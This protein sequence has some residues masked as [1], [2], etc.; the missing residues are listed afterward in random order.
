PG[1]DGLEL[2]QKVRERDADCT[3][4]VM[5]AFGAVDTAVSAMRLGACDYLTKPLNFEEL[6]I[7]IERALER[8]R[9]ES[10]AGTLRQ[11]LSERYR[12]DNI[13]GDSQPMQQVYKVVEQVAPSRATVL[14][15]G[16]SGTGKELV[17][18]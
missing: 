18:A 11:R 16:E 5:T 3:V 6:M 4:I 12:L 10:E 2:M 17:A 7:V 14:L 15:Q 13:I 8:R 1:M 9:L